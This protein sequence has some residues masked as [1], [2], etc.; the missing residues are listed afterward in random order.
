MQEHSAQLEKL[1]LAESESCEL[2]MELQSAAAR[3]T[4]LDTRLE[5]LNTSL[6]EDLGSKAIEAQKVR[7]KLAGGGGPR[8][9]GANTSG[10]RQG[11]N[12][13]ASHPWRQ[14]RAESSRAV[15]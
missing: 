5:S 4:D 11:A 3:S 8:G 12:P 13:G 9:G 1:A 7:G 10:S 6:E 2:W 15:P 14:C